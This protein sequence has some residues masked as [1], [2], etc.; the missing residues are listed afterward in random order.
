MNRLLPAVALAIAAIPSWAE[1]L[2]AA[3]IRAL[4]DEHRLPALGLFREFLSLPND[5]NFPGDILRMIEWMEDAFRARG[6]GLQ[7]IPT[8][9]SPLLLASRD[10][11]P[12]L[13]TV[14]VYLQ[15][16]GA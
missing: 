14:L 13:P 15:A 6:F 2:P 10:V 12:G 9:G 5:A 11:D 1:P 3:S 8:D 4:A 16:D 7:R